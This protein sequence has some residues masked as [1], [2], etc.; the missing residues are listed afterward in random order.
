[1][2]WIKKSALLTLF[3]AFG[4]FANLQAQTWSEW[5][6]QRKTQR[7]YLIEQLA[8][9]KLY[10]GYLKKGYEISRSGLTFIKDASQGELDLH[11]AF[12]ASLKRVSPLVRNYGKLAGIIQMQLDISRALRALDNLPQMD[13]AQQ[14]YISRVSDQ[15]RA[16]NQANLE[17][18]ALVI[19]S[20]RV[21]LSDDQRLIR[22]DRLYEQMEQKVSFT[23][24]FA[25]AVRTLI[26]Q[27]KR[28][29]E[30]IKQMEE[31]YEN[32]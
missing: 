8:A 31:W 9:L 22:I 15:V 27:R 10:A 25:G 19:T 24:S 6:S 29:M 16:E 2:E 28:E 11:G 5:F 1:M 4:I 12:F 13:E 7:K 17:E 21:E 30:S 23:F 14:R 18:L 3:C 26:S 20:G 32:N